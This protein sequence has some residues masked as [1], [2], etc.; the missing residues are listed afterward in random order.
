MKFPRF[1]TIFY[2]FLVV[3]VLFW[4]AVF[5]LLQADSFWQ[6]AGPRL[7]QMVNGQIRGVVTVGKFK[8]NPFSG[9]FLQDLELTSPEGRIFQAQELEVRL[10]FFSLLALRPSLRLALVKPSLYLRQDREGR[11]NLAQLLPPRQTPARQVWLP[12][13]A[14]HLEPLA[15]KGGEV[16]L[17]QPKGTQRYHDLNLNLALTL[18][19]PL[20]KRQSIEVQHLA[21]SAVTPWGSY[22]LA[23]GFAFSPKRVQVDSLLLKSGENLLL[24]LS[25]VVPLTD[26]KKKLR[27]NGALG[28]IPGAVFARFWEGWPKAWAASGEIKI[29]GSLSQATVNFQGRVS[30]AVFSLEVALSR[31][32]ESWN[33]EGFLDI[34]EVPPEMLAVLAPAQKE[35]LARATPLKARLHLQGS[36][37][38]WPP[39]QF[40]WTLRLEPFNY[41]QL[42]LAQARVSLTGTDKQQK[43]EAALRGNFGRVLLEGQGS[44]LKAPQGRLTVKLEEFQPGPLGLGAPPGS[45]ISGEFTGKAAVTGPARAEKVSVTGEV[46]AAGRVGEHPLKELR[47]RFTWEKPRLTIQELRG[48]V[49]NLLTELQGTVEAEKINIT[50]RGRTVPGGSWPV[51]AGVGGSLSWDGRVS[52]SLAEP[53]Y[54]LRVNGKALSWDKFAFKSLNLGVKGR[55]LPPRDGTVDLKAQGVTT[56]GGTFARVNLTSRGQGGQWQFN[57]KASSPPKGPQAEMAGAA[58]FRERPLALRV[59]RLR[60]Q[61][62][63]LDLK[64]QGPVQVRFLPGLE[65]PTATFLV[66]GGMVTAQAD[67]KNG[68]ITAL[69][70]VR[71]LPVEITRVK[72]L[73]GKIQARLTLEGAA[74]SPQMAG[75]ISLVSGK[76]RDFAFQSVQTTLNYSDN[77]LALTGSVQGTHEVGR[78]SLNGRLPLRFALSPWQFALL[79]EDMDVKL[80]AEGANLAL[81]TLFTPEVQKADVPLNLQAAVGGRMNAP[82][83]RGQLRWEEGQIT[84]RQAGAAY[85]VLPGSLNWENDRITLPQLTL[86][87]KGT[88][89]ATAAINLQGLEPQQVTAQVQFDDFQAL[90]KMGSEAFVSGA[91]NLRGPWSSLDLQG[92]LSIPR[93]TLNPALLKQNGTE[94]PADYILV[95]APAVKAQ[96]GLGADLP[97]P[98]QSMKIAIH[99]TA[100]RHVRVM[101]KMAQIALALDL[102]IKKRPGDQVLVRGFIRSLHG[103]ID[104]YGKEFILKRGLVTLPG[105]P[106]QEPYLQARAIHEMTDATFIVDVS[107]PVNNPKIDLSSSPAMPPNELLSYL[108]FDRPSSTLSKQEF[109]VTQQAVGVLGGIT[110][111][112]I[113]EFLG[114]DFPILGN[115]SIKGSQ[116]AIGVTKPITKR[117]TLSV[118]RKLNPAQGD[119][120]VQLRLQYRINRHFSLEAEGGQSRSGA[121]ALFNYEW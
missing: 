100:A 27:V 67:L 57:F 48:Q 33:Y 12:I 30:Q 50:L 62:Q 121:D 75:Q 72:G 3:L 61:G 23:G 120:A 110:A 53:A 11:W 15:I 45:L 20:T 1:R 97:G 81:V 104:V 113:Q 86:K 73:H 47:A 46:R 90:N 79:P 101:D 36:G 55:G 103:K 4:G 25:G 80:R 28:P 77:S 106:G 102:R 74:G 34:K 115:A 44:L 85:Q 54:T 39:R 108:L 116:G 95:G 19:H 32:R 59:E 8:G 87:S 93:A 10:S 6:W 52:G 99:V 96:K 64:N 114:K 107:G 29:T 98:Y 18:T 84:L 26:G 41:R 119:D 109:D 76:W 69:L 13:S 91:F 111:N 105:V 51:P 40:A 58:D 70:S 16:S 9:Y 60:F 24:S 83:I 89:K 117:V 21:L 66:N 82:R 5:F 35:E 118:E 68:Q 2:V 88:A 43:L 78:I 42:Q 92:Q 56:P 38:G 94:L 63:G 22:N 49:G 31:P 17:E 65:L 14:L 71:D 37:L 7:V 112:K